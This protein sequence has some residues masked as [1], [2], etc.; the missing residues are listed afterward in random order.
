MKSLFAKI[1]LWFWF[2][3]AITVVGSAF[4]SAL[5]VN[6]NDFEG[7]PVARL[8]TLQLAEARN[9]YETGGRPA[10]QGF[11]ETIQRVYDARGVLTDDRGRDL[12]SGEDRADLV[13]RARRRALYVIFRSD[14]TVARNSEDGRYWFFFI[15]PR[16]HV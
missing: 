1:L 10:L 8:V 7:S 9:A 12:L 6:K 5:N 2:A 4:I 14:S 11:L 3:L 16:T 13:R 15:V